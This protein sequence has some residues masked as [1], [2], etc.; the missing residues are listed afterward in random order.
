MAKK[1]PF[2]DQDCTE[3]C[4]L[5]IAPE[6]VNELVLNRLS[7]LGVLH[8]DG[9]CSLKTSALSLNRFIFENTTTRAR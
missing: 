1:C 4:A 8:K 6:E 5:F 3:E 2:K 7:S 9:I